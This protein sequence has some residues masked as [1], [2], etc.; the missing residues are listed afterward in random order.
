M[1]RGRPV[2]VPAPSRV[3]TSMG[4]AWTVPSNSLATT[5]CSPA[6]AFCSSRLEAWPL[7]EQ[8]ARRQ[9]GFDLGRQIGN[10]LAL[11]G[12]SDHRWLRRGSALSLA[13]MGLLGEGAE[14][15]AVASLPG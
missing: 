11:A 9:I 8:H 7:G 3:L 10:Q 5:T 15:R 2:A 12:N 1:P 6:A 14:F 13:A 4:A